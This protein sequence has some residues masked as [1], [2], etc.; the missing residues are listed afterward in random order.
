[1]TGVEFVLPKGFLSP[2]GQLLRYG[3]MRLATA[4]DELNGRSPMPIMAL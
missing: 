1:M 3:T 2:Q 4:Q